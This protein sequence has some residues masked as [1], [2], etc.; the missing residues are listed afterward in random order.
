[1]LGLKSMLYGGKLFYSKHSDKLD[2]SSD[3]MIT[4]FGKQT[5]LNFHFEL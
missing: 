1:M 3:I 2:L 5:A 4:Y